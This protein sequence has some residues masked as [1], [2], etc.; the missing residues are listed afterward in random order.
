MGMPALARLRDLQRAHGLRALKY[1]SVSVVGIAVTQIL[2]VICYQLVGMTAAWSN[3]TAVSGASIPA[4]L[5]NRQ[6]VWQ[7]SGR[8][9]MRREVLP[10]WGISLLGLIISTVAVGFVSRYWDSQLAVSGTN[11]ASFG[12]LWIGKYLVLDSIMFGPPELA[13]DPAQP[14]TTPGS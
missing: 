12:V 14:A 3:F 4:Y 10:F 13:D 6:W 2:L 9:S 5:L 11:I 7:K 8:H 1:A